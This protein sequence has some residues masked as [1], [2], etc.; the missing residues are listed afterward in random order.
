MIVRARPATVGTTLRA[1]V[2]PADWGRARI[3]A[4]AWLLVMLALPF[5]EWIGGVPARTAGVVL[6]VVLLA[7]TVL[8]LLA[9]AAGAWAALRIGAGIVGLAWVAEAVGAATDL[10]FGPYAYT[11]LLQPQ[12]AGVPVV[13]PLA[14]LMGLPPAWA[15]AARIAGATRGP[16]FVLVAAGAMT[17]WDLFL[18]PQMVAWGLW[19]WDIEGAYFGIPL[20]NFAGW[21]LVSALITVV[22]RPARLPLRPLV[23]LYSVTWLL[24]AGG[25]PLFWGL[26][27]PG[28]V[29][30]V[31]M[32]TFVLRAWRP[33][34]PWT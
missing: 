13:I 11:G 6:A 5:A 20:Q 3:A 26:V 33:V 24:E 32:G 16:A 34:R 9:H 28:V 23:L 7:A 31:V 8:L 29:G 15:V 19:A 18:D 30:A 17:A 1:L 25:L 10:P 12:L 22:V 14:W 2:G 21:L 4:G 27:G